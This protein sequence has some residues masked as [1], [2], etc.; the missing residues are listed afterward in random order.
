MLEIMCVCLGAIQ[1]VSLFPLSNPVPSL[2]CFF[3]A[4]SPFVDLTDPF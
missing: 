4:L 3:G 1:L 2:R